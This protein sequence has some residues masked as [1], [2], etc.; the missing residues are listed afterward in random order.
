[1]ALR[2]RM[3]RLRE[4]VPD[5]GVLLHIVASRGVGRIR[6]GATRI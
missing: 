2:P 5:A 4:L 3:V 1:V 6:F